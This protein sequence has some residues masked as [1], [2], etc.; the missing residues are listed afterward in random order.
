MLKPDWL[1][2]ERIDA[3]CAEIASAFGIYHLC[4][5][6]SQDLAEQAD[7]TNMLRAAGIHSGGRF[8]LRGLREVDVLLSTSN[9][10]RI[11]WL[12]SLKLS[13]TIEP[14]HTLECF[15]QLDPTY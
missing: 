13:A 8:K 4:I 2:D 14:A 7:I 15:N 1:T 3:I 5:D 11:A 6:A 12:Q 9:E 10:R